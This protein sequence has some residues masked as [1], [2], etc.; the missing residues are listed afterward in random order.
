MLDA[1]KEQEDVAHANNSYGTP[2]EFSICTE[3]RR[4]DK[5]EAKQLGKEINDGNFV[6]SLRIFSIFRKRLQ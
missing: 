2:E 5:A 3:E 6:L 4:Y 1:R